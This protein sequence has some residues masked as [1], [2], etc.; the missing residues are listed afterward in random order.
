MGLHIIT[1][2]AQLSVLS[3]LKNQTEI[4]VDIE[5]G[6]KNGLIPQQSKIRLIQIATQRDVFLIDL[7]HVD[8][9]EIVRE[10]LGSTKITKI[11]HNAK[12]D[13][14]HLLFHYQ[15]KVKSVFCTYLASQLI[16]SGNPHHRHSLDAVAQRFLNQKV[17]K[18]LQKSN[19]MATLSDEQI[20]YAARDVELLIPLFHAMKIQLTR[21]KLKKVSQLEFRTIAPVAQMELNGIY[22]S[23]VIWDQLETKYLSEQNNIAEELSAI[24]KDDQ[25]LPG[26]D[27]INLHSPDQVKRALEKRGHKLTSTSEKELRALQGDDPVI[28]KILKFRHASRIVQSTLKTFKEHILEETHRVHPS[29][30]QISSASGRFSCSEPNIQQVPR[31]KDIRSAFMPENGNLFVIADY[32][33]VE[34]RVAAGLSHDP[35]ML[36]AYKK[37]QDLHKVTAALTSGKPYD[38]ITPEERQAAKAINFG[39]IYAMGPKGLQ[40]S[41]KTSYG[42]EMSQIEAENFHKRFFENYSGIASWHENLE[43][44][45]RKTRYIR[46]AA[47]R[48]RKYQDGN[49]KITEL[50]NVPVQGTAAEIL[51][52]ALCIFYE[53]LETRGLQAKLVAIIH[54]EIIVETPKDYAETTKS[55]LVDCMKQAA[56][57][58]VPDIPFEIDASIANSWAGKN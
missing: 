6:G 26:F 27:S 58:L 10:S 16:S 54:D 15:I 40:M 36:E 21:L 25:L 1:S 41:A 32:S 42:V 24:L 55:A 38:Q 35:I 19:W 49:I 14:K 39:L 8:L 7:M 51:K 30:F 57:W 45:G 20:Q 34:L 5:T 53:Q 33:Q 56:R 3:N 13:L 2:R 47:G 43:A 44:A 29:Y 9:P 52:S 37:G 23:Q 46:T 4:A 22:L 11:F 17:D 12:F 50:F 48:I 18:S 28:S 31:E